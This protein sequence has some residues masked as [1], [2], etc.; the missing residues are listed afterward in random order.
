[1]Y[2]ARFFSSF[3]FSLL[4]FFSFSFFFP[5]TESIYIDST[6]TRLV[7]KLHSVLRRNY[8]NKI[9]TVMDSNT[10]KNDETEP[11]SL[12]LKRNFKLN[13]SRVNY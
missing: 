2:Q 9:K 5:C 11:R 1:M 13:G 8:P 4:R 12:Q 7:S 10:A 6:R 3:L